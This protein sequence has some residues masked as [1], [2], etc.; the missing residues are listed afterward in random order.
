[1]NII[2][3]VQNQDHNNSFTRERCDS[4]TGSTF[5]FQSTQH[6]HNKGDGVVSSLWIAERGVSGAE[7]RGIIPH[8]SLRAPVDSLIN[9]DGPLC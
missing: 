1:M 6:H 3:S 4:T 2:E 8:R 5:N 7:R 9:L